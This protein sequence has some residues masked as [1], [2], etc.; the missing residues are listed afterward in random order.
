MAEWRV[1]VAG[2]VV[3]RLDKELEQGPL[4]ADG[5]YL[6]QKKRV[7]RVAG[8]KVEIYSKEHPPPHFHVVRDGESNSFRIDDC[9]P[10]NENGGLKKYFR[11]IQKWYLEN[12]EELIRVWNE[13]RPSGCPV[14]EY[15]SVVNDKKA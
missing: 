13:T 1:P 15:Y 14:G 3:K 5:K 9:S 2:D 12:H 11:N 10:L 8:C 4:A 6:K 7:G